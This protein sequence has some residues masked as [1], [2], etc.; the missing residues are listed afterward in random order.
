MRSLVRSEEQQMFPIRLA[1]GQDD[2]FGGER[3]DTPA[4]IIHR[5]DSERPFLGETEA[6]QGKSIRRLGDLHLHSGRVRRGDLGRPQYR[7]LRENFA[8]Y[9]GDEVIL[10][11]CILA[12][13]LSEFDALHGHKFFPS[14]QTTFS[15]YSPSR[16]AVNCSGVTFGDVWLLQGGFV[17][18]N[19][20]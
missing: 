1:H 7:V 9:L 16:Q 17:T 20:C 3:H 11:G 10:A 8:I 4:W 15:E 12:P 19:H 18:M 13:D 6:R 2:K 5:H 14:S